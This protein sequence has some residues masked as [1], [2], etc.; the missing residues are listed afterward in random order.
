V[1]Y[2]YWVAYALTS[3]STA[4]QIGEPD[5]PSTILGTAQDGVGP[6]DRNT[7]RQPFA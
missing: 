7:V 6:N 3:A 4:T 5:D 1:F 2:D